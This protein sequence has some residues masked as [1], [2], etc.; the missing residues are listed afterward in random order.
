MYKLL[1]L[2]PAGC[3]G[4]GGSPG[5]S[6]LSTLVLADPSQP[7]RSLRRAPSDSSTSPSAIRASAAV[8]ARA[9]H[10][11]ELAALRDPRPGERPRWELK[12]L[13]TRA[14]LQFQTDGQGAAWTLIGTDPGF[15]ATTSMY[16]TRIVASHR[17]HR[18]Q[19]CKTDRKG[20]W[21]TQPC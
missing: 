21:M 7:L 1:L 12:S 3:G 20:I 2:V 11:I 9:R 8:R 18:L 14:P 19:R 10:R 13:R 15:E 6:V 5:E 17:A 4:V 16:Y